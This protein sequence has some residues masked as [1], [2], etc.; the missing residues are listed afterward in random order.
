MSAPNKEEHL[1]WL[2]KVFVC[3]EKSG[4]CACTS[5]NSW[6]LKCLIWGTGLMLKDFIPFPTQCKQ[7]LMHLVLTLSRSWRPTW[8]YLPTMA[9]SVLV[10]LYRLLKKRDNSGT[11]KG[12]KTQLFWNQRSC[13]HPVS[14]SFILMLTF[15]SSWHVTHPLMEW[16][17][18]WHIGCQMAVRSQSVL[19]LR[20]CHLQNRTM[21]NW[22]R[23]DWHACMTW[24]SSTHTCLS[25]HLS[26]SQATHG[27][28][29][30]TST[31]LSWS[32][33]MDQTLVLSLFCLWEFTHLSYCSCSLQC[34]Y[35][36]QISSSVVPSWSASSATTSRSGI[37]QTPLW[38][39]LTSILGRRRI[40]SWHVSLNVFNEDGQNRLTRTWV[41][42]LRKRGV[43]SAWRV[44]L[45]GD[46]GG[47]ST[48][49]ARVVHAGVAWGSPWHKSHEVIGQNVCVVAR[50]RQRLWGVSLYVPLMS[51]EPVIP[52]KCAI[53]A[54]SLSHLPLG[55]T[56]LGLHWSFRGW[57]I[58]GPHRC[59]F[60]MGGTTSSTTVE[61]L[62]QVFAQFGIMEM[63]ATDNVTH[64]LSVWS[65]NL[66]WRPTASNI[67]QLL[68][69][70]QYLMA[71]QSM[72]C[73]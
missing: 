8:A 17:P 23:K 10:P 45:V 46:Q 59:A 18:C 55:K 51:G 34:R 49:R 69:T 58:F 47:C 28:T 24:G 15:P 3:L 7:W 56:A 36:E 62:H 64:V 57:D 2:G 48:T 29:Q 27:I 50:V 67:S 35:I 63:V 4:L 6:C 68:L 30:W 12:E 71:W 40:L 1:R 14:F 9:S 54:W 32:I 11:G 42:T 20:Y 73:K 26:W 19:P 43:V 52:T 60:R 5:V 13:W 38:R 72:P 33:S 70:N 37:R 66:L 21:P 25:M 31:N 53:A 41:S 44:Y 16:E 39:Q 22:R 61:C 65:L